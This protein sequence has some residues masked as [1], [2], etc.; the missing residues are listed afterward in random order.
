MPRYKR[1]LYIV[2]LIL[3]L[4]TL[5]SYL[6]LNK[7]VGETRKEENLFKKLTRIF[8]ETSYY[9]NIT[10]NDL[11]DA[12]YIGINS[13]RDLSNQLNSLEKEY[14]DLWEEYIIY[15]LFVVNKSSLMNKMWRAYIAY[16][17]LTNTTVID[18]GVSKRLG[19]LIDRIKES[20]EYLKKCDVDKALNIYS[21]VKPEI[22]ETMY[23]LNKS[24]TNLSMAKPSD[25]LNKK[26]VVL[27]NKTIDLIEEI[28]DGLSKYISLMETVAKN[29]DTY[30][31]MCI[32]VREGLGKP[33]EDEK[34]M[35]RNIT[36]ILDNPSMGKAT[37]QASSIKY[38]VEKLLIGESSNPEKGGGGGAG[39]YN[40]TRTD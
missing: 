17:H 33:G 22:M 30:R 19:S 36:I 25:L 27:R 11:S 21:R 38:M 35:A 7:P 10:T 9:L 15:K 23:L 5:L 8:V 37:D 20:L 14:S 34:N 16:Y 29:P 1:Y 6:Y 4:L 26:H 28:L 18:H 31:N 39:Y 40:Y 3:L 13:T 2:P 24:L 32:Y 12:Y